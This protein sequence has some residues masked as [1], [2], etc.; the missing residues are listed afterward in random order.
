MS[1]ISVPDGLPA[2]RRYLAIAVLLMSLVLVVL[3]GAIANIALPSM[4]KSLHAS[5]A[6]TVW[7]VSSYQLAVLIALLPC[8]V[9]GEKFGPRRVFLIGIAVFVVASGACALSV[10]LPML[11]ASRFLQGLGVGPSWRWP[12]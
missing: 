6:D 1:D 9:L 2:P 5:A 10:N 3:D 7:V 11:V 12:P 4:A 8:G